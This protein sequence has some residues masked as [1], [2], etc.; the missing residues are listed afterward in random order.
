MEKPPT[1]LEAP[2]KL[3]QLKLAIRQLLISSSVTLPAEALWDQIRV[4]ITTNFVQILASQTSSLPEENHGPFIQL[5]ESVWKS[6]KN[7]LNEDELE[8]D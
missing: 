5:L 7:R 2:G 3:Q 1:I 6:M 4:L 8:V